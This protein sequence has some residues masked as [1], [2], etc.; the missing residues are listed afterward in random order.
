[1]ERRGQ[2]G[3]ERRSC[4]RQFPLSSVALVEFMIFRSNQKK[5]KF[6]EIAI[7]TRF[8]KRGGG[9]KKGSNGCFRQFLVC[10]VALVEFMTADR[11][12]PA[13]V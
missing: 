13:R 6:F 12:N 9:S 10:S 5:Y 3:K 11:F 7:V 2:K 1:M 4:F 8:L